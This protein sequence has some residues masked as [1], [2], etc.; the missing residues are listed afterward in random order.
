MGFACVASLVISMLFV[1]YFVRA[2]CVNTLCPNL[3]RFNE[4]IFASSDYNMHTL[5]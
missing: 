4:P 3:H 5:L 1:F 2:N